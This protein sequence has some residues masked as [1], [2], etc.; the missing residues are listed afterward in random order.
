MAKIDGNGGIFLSSNNT[1][2]LAGWYNEVLGLPL[3]AL[4]D[5]VYYIELYYRSLTNS[6]KKLHTVFAIMPEKEPLN[7]KRNQAMINYRVDNLEEFV[8]KLDEKNIKVDPIHTGPD[9]EG[10]GKFTHLIDPEGK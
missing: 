4:E 9:A 1:K 8:K 3:Q 10:I 6:N 7:E 2:K 5:D